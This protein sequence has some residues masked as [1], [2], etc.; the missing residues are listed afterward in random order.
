[1]AGMEQVEFDLTY[2]D[3]M[4]PHHESIIALAEVARGELT[5]PSL[6]AMAEKIIDT[7]VAE[8]KAMRELRAKWYPG[9]PT[10]DMGMMMDAMP[11]MGTDMAHMDEQMDAEW[12]VQAFC[13]AENKDL[14]FIQQVI[15]HHRM[16]IEVSEDGLELAV[17]PELVAIAE[18]V[19]E[20]QEQEIEELEEI[21]TEITG[22]ATPAI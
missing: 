15:P 19:I 8:I 22:E 12:Q 2:I 14:P 20:A 11:G 1:M 21:R 16:A 13:A 3:M 18:L 6:I 10:V 7:Q 4:I 17:H 5:H 9:A